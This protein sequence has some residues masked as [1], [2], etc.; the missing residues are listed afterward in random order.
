MI[1]ILINVITPLQGVC[2]KTGEVG[3]QVM[4]L[5]SMSGSLAYVG[6][7]DRGAETVH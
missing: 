3:L 6:V 4:T 2:V 7:Q 5:L 1:L